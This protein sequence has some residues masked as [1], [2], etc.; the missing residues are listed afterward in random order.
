LGVIKHEA[1]SSDLYGAGLRPR[2]RVKDMDF[3]RNQITVRAGKGDK[4]RVTSRAR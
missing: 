3:A 1:R 2:L 4:D